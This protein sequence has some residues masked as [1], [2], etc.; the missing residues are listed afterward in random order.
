LSSV[1]KL[2]DPDPYIIYG[3]GSRRANNIRIRLDPDPQHC[4]Y[5]SYFSKTNAMPSIKVTIEKMNAV[6]YIKVRFWKNRTLYP[7]SKL[8]FKVT[9]PSFVPCRWRFKNCGPFMSSINLLISISAK[10]CQNCPIHKTIYIKKILNSFTQW[11]CKISKF[12]SNSMENDAL[13]KL[14]NMIGP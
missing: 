4:L 7:I 14:F 6:S 10:Y 1:F 13:R 2:L 5:Q 9:L 3:S 11:S 12:N 8:L